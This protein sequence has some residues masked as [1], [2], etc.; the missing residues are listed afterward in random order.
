ML[1]KQR[2]GRLHCV[3]LYVKSHMEDAMPMWDV[4][5]EFRELRKQRVA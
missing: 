4:D 2:Y 3:G 5:G 1:L